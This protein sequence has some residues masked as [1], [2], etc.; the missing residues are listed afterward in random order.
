MAT[1]KQKILSAINTKTA[2]REAIARKGQ[3]ITATTKFS[4][5]PAKIDAIETGIDTSD[6][7]ATANHV[8]SD[9]TFY[10]NGM[11]LTGKIPI[12]SQ[13]SIST[14][15]GAVTIPQGYYPNAVTKSVDRVTLA[16]P[17]ISVSDAG[18]VTA[19]VNQTAGYVS[20][21]EKS[22]QYYLATQAAK[23][24]TPGTAAKTAIAA[25]TYA[26]GAVTVQGDSK[27]VADNI[28]SGVSIFGV[29]GTLTSGAKDPSFWGSRELAPTSDK[30]LT[31][32]DMTS[33]LYTYWKYMWIGIY[34]TSDL[35]P[36]NSISEINSGYL[37]CKINGTN[38]VSLIDGYLGCSNSLSY[39]DY[40]IPNVS[41]YGT[42]LTISIDV[43]W[44]RFSSNGKY[45]IRMYGY[46]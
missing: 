34:R 45:K 17:T 3:T 42:T 4:D 30:V 41:A 23:T 19:K 9:Y 35:K 39:C 13:T 14:D 1:L 18:V 5:Y 37:V 21:S 25:G 43:T 7:T 38:D 33:N 36:T 26:T 24:I 2:I 22:N 16:T 20:A 46:T 27:L 32:D 10:A 44:M 28:R 6:A 15:S 11:K 40:A 12:R 29:T 31:I 8:L